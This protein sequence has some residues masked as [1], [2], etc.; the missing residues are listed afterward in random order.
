MESIPLSGNYPFSGNH[1]IYLKLFLLVEA[2]TFNVSSSFYWNPFRIFGVI[3]FSGS[4]SFN[5]VSYS[6]SLSFWYK[7][8]LLGETISFDGTHPILW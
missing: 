7:P 4:R 5:A 6:E 3:L 8:S 2:N 1:F